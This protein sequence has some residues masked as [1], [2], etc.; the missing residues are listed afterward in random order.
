MTSNPALTPEV[1]FCIVNIFFKSISPKQAKISR[2]EDLKF[3][4]LLPIFMGRIEVE[5]G[6]GR[7]RRDDP[8]TFG[9][10]LE[11]MK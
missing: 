1:Q 8:F 3:I 10:D 5:L 7:A 4:Y 6:I 11:R 2:I 9:P